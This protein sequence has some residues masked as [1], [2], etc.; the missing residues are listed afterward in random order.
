MHCKSEPCSNP[1]SAFGYVRTYDT[2]IIKEWEKKC[3]RLVYA[4]LEIMV[5]TSKT[6]LC[7][8]RFDYVD[9]K[10]AGQS[11]FGKLPLFPHQ[12]EPNIL[13]QEVK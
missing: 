13:R 6:R 9:Y 2:A 5:Y 4:N 8:A 12:V 7:K 3:N 10:P 1:L 11:A